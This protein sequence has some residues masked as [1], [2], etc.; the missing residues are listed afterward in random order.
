VQFDYSGDDMRVA[1]TT[2][3]EETTYVH[4]A[5]TPLP[6]VLTESSPDLGALY[7]YGLDLVS[8][9]T[10]DGAATWYHT[11]GIGSVRAL[12]DSGGQPSATYDYDAF[13]RVRIEEGGGENP[14]TFAGE[15]YDSVIG[16]FYLRSRYLDPQTGRF[17][18]R[19]PNV[20]FPG[21]TQSLPGFTYALNNPVAY[22]DRNGQFVLP[23][24]AVAWWN[25]DF[26][27]NAADYVGYAQEYEER[28]GAWYNLPIE[29]HEW[30]ELFESGYNPNLD[31]AQ[32]GAFGVSRLG[33]QTGTSLGGP[34]PGASGTAPGVL[35]IVEMFVRHVMMAV[36]ERS[37]DIPRRVQADTPF[38]RSAGPIEPPGWEKLWE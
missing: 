14:F 6:L 18:S 33:R 24:L 30:Q 25:A 12:T 3:G 11:D 1:A 13:G 32:T 22:A 10:S 26:M 27:T 23:L 7:L 31:L 17:V 4:D 19:D 9:T 28:A 37:M 16:L 29:S 2:N 21:S 38:S 5:T 15:Q 36:A 8:R 20:G 34:P 35:N